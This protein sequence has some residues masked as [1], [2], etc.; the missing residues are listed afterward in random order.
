M[1]VASEGASAS[2]SLSRSLL[3]HAVVVHPALVLETRRTR[4]VL[5]SP[6]PLTDCVAQTTALALAGLSDPGRDPAEAA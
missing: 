3:L 4:E 1:S 6:Y 2:A 5:A